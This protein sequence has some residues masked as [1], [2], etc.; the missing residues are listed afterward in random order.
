VGSALPKA[1]VK[2]K[3]Q[4]LNCLPCNRHDIHPT[5]LLSGQ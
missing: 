3:A 1:V 5:V 2:P 4:R